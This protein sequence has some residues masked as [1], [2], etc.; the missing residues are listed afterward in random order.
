MIT[1]TAESLQ[2]ALETD[3]WQSVLSDS[4]HGLVEALQVPDGGFTVN[5]WT[6]H[7]VTGGYAVSVHPEAQRILGSVREG[8]LLEYLLTHGELAERS[9]NA[10]GGWKDPA[11]GRIYLDVTTVVDDLDQ[12][13]KLARA[14]DQLAVYG[15]AE[16]KSITTY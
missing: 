5:A 8:D 7:P 14:N 9:G 2:N 15:F 1:A 16:G 12:A 13:L 3:P 11:D 10:F 6:L 4:L